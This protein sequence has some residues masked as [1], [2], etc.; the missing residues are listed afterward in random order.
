MDHTAPFSIQVEFVEGC[1]LRCGFCGIRNIRP[2]G[3]KDNRSGPYKFMSI[4]TA[5][6]LAQQIEASGWPSRIEFAMH[7]EPTMHPNLYELVGIFRS[8]LPKNSLMMTSNGVP[9]LEGDIV[10]NINQLFDYGLNCLAI[11]DYRPHVVAPKVRSSASDI[12]ANIYE[13]PEI[14]EETPNKRRKPTERVVL[15][16]EDISAADDGTHSNLWNHAG[17]AF[18]ASDEFIDRACA[19]PFRELSVRWDGNVAICCDDWTGKYAVGNINDV[20][21]QSIWNHPRMQSARKVLLRGRHGLTPCAGCTHRTYRNG[22]LPFNGQKKYG[23]RESYPLPTEK[24]WEIIDDAVAEI[25]YSPP[26]RREIPVAL[27]VK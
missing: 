6:A 8:L 1:N 11:D 23:D 19:K 15:L 20:G 4:E 22:L 24:D 2:K 25:E 18:E 10:K 13:Y 12:R 7:G 14:R 5:T 9:L 21:A 3:D 17:S 16:V 26:V 27:R